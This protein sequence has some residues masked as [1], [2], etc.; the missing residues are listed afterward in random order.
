LRFTWHNILLRQPSELTG[1]GGYIQL[2]NQTIKLRNKLSRSGPTI[3]LDR[4]EDFLN[5]INRGLDFPHRS[6]I[7]NKNRG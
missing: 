7:R 5:T 3:L 6:A 2:S 4:H 1:R